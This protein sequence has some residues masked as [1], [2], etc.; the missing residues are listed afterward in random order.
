METPLLQLGPSE[1]YGTAYFG[2]ETETGIRIT[3]VGGGTIDTQPPPY[4]NA[5]S[6]TFL[7]KLFNIDR[8]YYSPAAA[9]FDVLSN[10]GLKETPCRKPRKS[11]LASFVTALHTKAEFMFCK[12]HQLVL[13]GQEPQQTKGHDDEPHTKTTRSAR[14]YQTMP[15]RTRLLTDDARTCTAYRRKQSDRV[16]TRRSLNTKRRAY[17]RSEQSTL[18][19]DC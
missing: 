18:F 2:S 16:R 17:Q 10:T 14:T 3:A 8:V 12:L 11:K 1:S 15:K 5:E 4:R 9:A 19:I 13:F 7:D 6:R